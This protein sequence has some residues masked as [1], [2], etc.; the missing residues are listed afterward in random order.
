G[1]PLLRAEFSGAALARALGAFGATIG[2]ATAVGPLVGGALT[3]TLGWRSIFYVNLPIGVA[4][5]ALGATRLP[6]SRHP[7]GGRSDWPGTALITVAL[8]A[9]VFALIRGNALGWASAAIVTLFVV[10]AV[11]M[12]GLLL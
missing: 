8:T 4:A 1:T 10:A 6:E 5:F 2:G 7:A 12:A 3:D 11:P 9:L